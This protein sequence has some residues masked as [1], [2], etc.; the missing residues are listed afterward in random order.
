MQLQ[1]FDYL[2]WKMGLEGAKQFLS[3]A[4]KNSYLERDKKQTEA[5]KKG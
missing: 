1:N 4:S 3:D 2:V 5:P